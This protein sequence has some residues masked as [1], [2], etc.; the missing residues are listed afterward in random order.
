MCIRDSIDTMDVVDQEK[1][2]S[3]GFCLDCHRAPEEHLRD[4]SDP[5]QKVTNLGWTHPD[6]EAGQLKQ[7]TDL[8]KK[9]DIH[10][11]MCIRDRARGV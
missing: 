6:G 1:S 2:L 3:M 10:P 9:L 5:A 7:G 4:L 11:Q 8:V